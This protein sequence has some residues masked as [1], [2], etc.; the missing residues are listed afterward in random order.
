LLVVSHQFNVVM[1]V[2]AVHGD[3][4]N[5]EVHVF[6]SKKYTGEPAESEEMTTEWFAEDSI[7]FDKMWLD[8]SEPLFACGL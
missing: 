3:S 4:N 2:L 7:P 6:A 8:V 1:W 5:L